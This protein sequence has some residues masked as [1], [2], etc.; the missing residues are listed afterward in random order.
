MILKRTLSSL[1]VLGYFAIGTLCNATVN[2]P[3]VDAAVVSLRTSCLEGGVEVPNCFNGLAQLETWMN[4][5]RTAPALLVKIGPGTFARGNENLTAAL[6]CASPNITLQGSGRSQSIIT[7][8]LGMFPSAGISILAGCDNF[9]VQDLKAKGWLHGAVS[10]NVSAKTNWVNVEVEGGSYGWLEGD[11]QPCANHN[12]R[13]NWHSSRIIANGTVNAGKGSSF[14]YDAICAQSWFFGSEIIAHVNGTTLST[15]FTLHAADA[16][17]HL[18]GSNAR[19]IVGSGANANNSDIITAETNS[20]VHIHGTGLDVV[21]NGSGNVAYLRAD[22]TSHFHA[23]ASAFSLHNAGTSTVTRLAGTGAIEAPYQW[24][25]QTSP[26]AIVSRSGADTYI[27][28]DCPNTADCSVGGN[29]PHTMIYRA[30]CT[31]AGSNQGPWY[32]T[33]TRFCR[34]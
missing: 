28:T 16:E 15:S 34:Q 6:N 21:H 23:N 8:Q 25:E 4:T 31:G 22:A 5:V 18:Y 9:N 7:T 11:S 27:E 24:G 1:A 32:D 29:F 17:V 3:P 26:P 19:L 2:S 14:A 12:G 10:A 20:V 33:V 13:H 30:E